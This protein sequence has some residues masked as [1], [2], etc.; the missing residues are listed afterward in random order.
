MAEQRARRH[1]Q[2]LQV[3]LSN[4]QLHTQMVVGDIAGLRQQIVEETSMVRKEIEQSSQ[5]T[6]QAVQSLQ[7]RCVSTVQGL[8][9]KAGTLSQITFQT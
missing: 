8:V 4:M 7:R 3:T 1:F 6:L 2:S 5:E 9:K